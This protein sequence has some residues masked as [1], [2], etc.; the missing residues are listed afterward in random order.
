MSDVQKFLCSVDQLRMASMKEPRKMEIL[1]FSASDSVLGITS[2][3]AV[4]LRSNISTYLP[5]VPSTRAIGERRRSNGDM[6]YC[7]L[8]FNN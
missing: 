2:A 7:V 5:T 1:A 8:K 4:I 6:R 3:E